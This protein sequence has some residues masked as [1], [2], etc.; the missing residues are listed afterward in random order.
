MNP[1]YCS[2]ASVYIWPKARSAFI[3]AKIGPLCFHLG[4]TSFT[5]FYS[6]KYIPASSTSCSEGANIVLLNRKM[7][8][9]RV[10]GR[11]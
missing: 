9:K 1:D 6:C 11:K 10:V 2:M 7:F 8:E 5:F 3:E 4:A